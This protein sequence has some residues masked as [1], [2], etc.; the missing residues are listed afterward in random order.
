MQAR[1]NHK[2]EPARQGVNCWAKNART[3]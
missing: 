1:T 3:N 2:L